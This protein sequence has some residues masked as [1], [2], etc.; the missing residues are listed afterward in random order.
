MEEDELLIELTGVRIVGLVWF[1]KWYMN[2]EYKINRDS[3]PRRLVSLSQLQ[4]LF[5]SSQNCR[6]IVK[7]NYN[8]LWNLWFCY[9]QNWL[10]LHFTLCGIFKGN[11][12]NPMVMQKYLR[13]QIKLGEN[14]DNKNTTLIIFTLLIAEILWLLAKIWN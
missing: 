3:Y 8:Y 11:R 9:Q 4:P 12:D 10:A 5:F 6:K 14:S 13:S 2:A 1:Q 7:V